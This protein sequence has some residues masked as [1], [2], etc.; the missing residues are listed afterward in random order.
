MRKSKS[1]TAQQLDAVKYGRVSS[2]EQEKEGF[3]IPAQFKLLDQYADSQGLRI[4][5]EFV[6]AETAKRTGRA[7]FGEMIKFLKRSSVRVLLVEKTD[8]L[9]RN[10]K[11]YVTID[12]LKSRNPLCKRK[13]D[14]FP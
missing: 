9:Y 1:H 6:D 10:L 14:S 12:E 4:V 2:K 8:R 13:C 3:S 5:R 11:D 7:G